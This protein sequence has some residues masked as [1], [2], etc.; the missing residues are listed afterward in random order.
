MA[1]KREGVAKP[2]KKATERD[3]RIRQA[4]ATECLLAVASLSLATIYKEVDEKAIRLEKKKHIDQAE[5]VRRWGERCINSS[6]LDFGHQ[7]YKQAQKKLYQVHDLVDRRLPRGNSTD[8]GYHASV[9]LMLGFLVD[10]VRHYYAPLSEQREWRYF[11]SVTNT[12]AEM[13]LANAK[14][15]EDYEAIGGELGEEAWE[16]VLYLPPHSYMRPEPQ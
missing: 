13:V 12:W 16:K 2:R 10:Q 9:W 14:E 5:R 3:K 11:G 7:T 1:K 8:L 6:T 4:K 15:G